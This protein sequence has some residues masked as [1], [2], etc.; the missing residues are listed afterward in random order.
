MD[1]R[2]RKPQQ[3]SLCDLPRTRFATCPPPGV[4]AW[5]ARCA[6]DPQRRPPPP[7]HPGSASNP[8]KLSPL[9]PLSWRRLCRGSPAGEPL[10]SPWGALV[11]F[12]ARL[13][14]YCCFWRLSCDW[15]QSR[16]RRRSREAADF[17][18]ESSQPTR[19]GRSGRQSFR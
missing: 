1:S 18:S 16:T 6:R 17:R 14:F 3:N 2:P 13:I 10:G 19:L 9:M 4:P 7:P 12:T 5:R 11:F 8:T 15:R